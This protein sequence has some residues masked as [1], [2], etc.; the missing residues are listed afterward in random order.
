MIGRIEN[1]LYRINN[2]VKSNFI[3]LIIFVIISV[4]A[5]ALIVAKEYN[6]LEYKERLNF[7]FSLLG[8]LIA[9][10][11][12]ILQINKNRQDNKELKKLEIKKACKLKH[13]NK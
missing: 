2:F 6:L 5:Y 1:I 9:F 13:S 11:L 8:W 7:R 12:V 3:Y 10:S 4:S